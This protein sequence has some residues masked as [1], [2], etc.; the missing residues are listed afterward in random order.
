MLSKSPNIRKGKE[1]YIDKVILSK[2]SQTQI[3]PSLD[4]LKPKN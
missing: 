4:N 1:V 3:F 2:V